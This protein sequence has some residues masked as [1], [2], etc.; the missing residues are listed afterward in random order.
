MADVVTLHNTAARAKLRSP[1]AVAVLPVLTLGIYHLVWWYRINREMRDYGRAHGCDLGQRPARSVLALFP[2]FLLI[3]PTLVA[4]ARGTE[5]VQAAAR[6]AGTE[7]V[8]GWVALLLY[9]VLPA[10]FFAYLQA[11]L[12][13]VWRA[14]IA[15]PPSARPRPE[16]AVEREAPMRAPAGARRKVVL[17][18]Y[19]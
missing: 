13:A 11:S 8:S 15:G 2:G 18:P 7:P 19:R 3:V 5:R 14:D 6:L 1:W 10:A 9:L 16:L 4:Y 12:N 17:G